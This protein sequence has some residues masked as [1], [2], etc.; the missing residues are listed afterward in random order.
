MNTY[1]LKHIILFYFLLLDFNSAC[2]IL[3]MIY[4]KLQLFNYALN[5]LFLFPIE[6]MEEKK[7]STRAQGHEHPP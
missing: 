5:T 3:L 6:S 7:G 1:N 2:S 4:T